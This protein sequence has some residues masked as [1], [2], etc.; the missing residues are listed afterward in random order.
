MYHRGTPTDGVFT[1]GSVNF[2]ESFRRIS[3]VWENARVSSFF[4]PTTSQIPDF[5]HKM[6]FDLFSY[7]PGEGGGYSK[8]FYT[9]RLRPEVQPLTLLYTI[10]SGKAPLSYTFYWK[11]APLSYTFWRRLRNKSLKQEVFLSFFHVARNKLKW[12]SHKLRLLD[13]F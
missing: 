12:N 11:K 9:R 1:L 13:L 3:K 2:C 10:F 7:R 6:V 8:K 4:I 5:I